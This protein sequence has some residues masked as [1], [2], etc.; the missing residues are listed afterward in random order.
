MSQS[1]RSS[2]R[3][4]QLNSFSVCAMLFVGSGVAH[5]QW[6][7][8]NLHP[9]GAEDSYALAASGGRQ[10]G[11]TVVEAGSEERDRAAMWT[12]SAASWVDLTPTNVV[13]AKC[14]A[15]DGNVQVGRYT[16]LNFLACQWSGN[17]SSWA[18]LN[19][20]GS[21]MSSANAVWG[22][23]QGGYAMVAGDGHAILW[24]GSATQY[25][26]LHSS[27][28]LFSRILGMTQGQQVG[29][30]FPVSS[31]FGR[32][33]LWSGTASSFVDLHPVSASY[34]YAADADT[35]Q[36]VGAAFVTSR[37]VASLW[38][39]TQASWVNLNPSGAT[40]SY[41]T[42]VL[43]GKQVGYAEIGGRKRAGMWTGTAA[44][45]FDLSAIRPSG[46]THTYATD[47]ATD[48]ANLY[49]CGYGYR[50]PIGYQALLWIH[51]LQPVCDSIDFN[52]DASLF[53]PQD[54]EAF[55]SKYSEGPCVPSQA[56]CNDIDF[57]N[58]SSLFDPCDINAFL[59]MYSEG[60][61][62]TCGA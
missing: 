50:P 43:A 34:S 45:W 41:L 8:V 17:A 49:V 24:N 28:H 11:Y 33:C 3:Y 42:G 6:T 27:A 18:N 60:P 2:H 51:P 22:N 26:D 46:I 40:S 13:K 38:T 9:P 59:V 1:A 20:A 16:G 15:I 31:D 14:Y 58:D 36:Q 32:A 55:L 39:G 47:I 56:T 25:V 61:C 19:L 12:G 48:G 5:A 21:D 54:I 23:Q 4:F 29:D 37:W 35:G 7:V 52:N 10:V 57:N 53:D 44:S 62:T 30:Y